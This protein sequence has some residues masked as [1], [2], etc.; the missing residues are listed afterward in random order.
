[1]KILL[2]DDIATNR[3]LLRAM[4]EAEDMSV[5]D[6]ADGIEALAILER[7]HVNAIITDILMPR[8]D[9]YR[10]CHEVRQREKLKHIALIHYTSTYTSPGD[11]QLSKTVGADM[12]LIKPVSAEVLLRS[13]EEAMR[14]ADERKVSALKGSD[15]AFVMQE[16]SVALVNKLEEKNT[17]AEQ[18]MAELR[19]ANRVLGE[20]K[21][22]LERRVEER[23]AK[24]E[25]AN[26]ELKKALAEVKELSGLLPICAWCKKIRDPDAYW[27]RVEDY[28]RCHSKAEFSHG[29]CPE[30]S[31][32]LK[33]E[34]ENARERVHPLA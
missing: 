5:L 33:A 10:L 19:R 13:L 8:M 22:S 7:E 25:A 21:E 18:A 30:C 12:Y 24:L 31:E 1:M 20:L 4:L 11:Q 15:T 34:S 23:T 9:G 3:K 17:E 2:V 28:I 27:H 6:A 14:H 26:L 16:Y 29:I 32:K